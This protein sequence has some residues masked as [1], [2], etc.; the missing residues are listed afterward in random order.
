MPSLLTSLLNKYSSA[1]SFS[2]YLSLLFVSSKSAEISYSDYKLLLE[3]PTELLED[4]EL[5][6]NE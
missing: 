2:F 3:E 5:L 1:S 4:G 6:L